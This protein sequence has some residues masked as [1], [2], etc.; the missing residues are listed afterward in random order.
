MGQVAIAWVLAQ[1][2]DIIPIPG[3]RRR[4]Y[5]EDNA[6]ATVLNLDKSD[7]NKLSK[8]FAVDVATGHRLPEVQ[9]RY[10]DQ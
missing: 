9:Q 6:G 3:T 8:A 2:T 1:G 5:L 7:L 10:I 4:K